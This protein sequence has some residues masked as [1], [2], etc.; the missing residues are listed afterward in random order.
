[1]EAGFQSEYNLLNYFPWS[2]TDKAC[3]CLLHPN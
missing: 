2:S 3:T 1:M